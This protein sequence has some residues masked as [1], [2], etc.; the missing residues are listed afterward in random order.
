MKNIWWQVSWLR[1]LLAAAATLLAG[2]IL[3]FCADV[4]H[5]YWCAQR[6]HELGS[7]LIA[8][9]VLIVIFDFWQKDALF[10]ELSESARY[11]RFELPTVAEPVI[12]S[13]PHW[14]TSCQWYSADR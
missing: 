14:L 4:W 3:L 5:G 8:A 11:A 1:T 7:V 9:V 6:L 12:L 2:V 10:R 13:E